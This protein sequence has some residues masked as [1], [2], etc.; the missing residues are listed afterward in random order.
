[1]AERRINPDAPCTC[2]RFRDGGGCLRHDVPNRLALVGLSLYR[3]TLGSPRQT[4]GD[5]G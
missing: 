4:G 3:L 5:H 1:M 2:I